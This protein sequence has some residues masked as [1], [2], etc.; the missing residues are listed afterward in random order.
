MDLIWENFKL[1][2]MDAWI[3]PSKHAVECKK[4]KD[5][6]SSSLKYMSKTFSPFLII[7]TMTYMMEFMSSAASIFVT[8]DV[9]WILVTST[10]F[11]N[12]HM[13]RIIYMCIQTCEMAGFQCW[14][15]LNV[16]APW[17][18]L[19]FLFFSCGC[20]P[21]GQNGVCCPVLFHNSTEQG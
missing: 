9:I 20:L 6:Y 2:G 21:K 10:F 14:W 18:S 17:G 1:N 16:Q 13:V 15:I 5:N 4:L 7:L 3:I 12:L 11:S 19:M 8:W